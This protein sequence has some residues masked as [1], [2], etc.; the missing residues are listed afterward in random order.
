MWL[1][2]LKRKILSSCVWFLILSLPHD[3]SYY[4]YVQVLN[5]Q[6]CN[7]LYHAFDYKPL[8]E[9]RYPYDILNTYR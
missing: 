9:S 7:T 8:P 5:H 6:P 1:N 3:L 2:N 4:Y